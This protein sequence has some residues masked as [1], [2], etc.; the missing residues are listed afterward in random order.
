MWFFG[1]KASGGYFYV[2]RKICSYIFSYVEVRLLDSTY[3]VAN[4]VSRSLLQQT[5]HLWHHLAMFF[6]DEL[7]SWSWRRP[8]GMPL[9]PIGGG[10]LN[11]AD[12]K[13]KIT[14]NVEHVVNR[15]TGIAPQSISDEVYISSP[16]LYMGF[17]PRIIF[18]KCVCSTYHPL[19]W[20]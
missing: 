4:N 14:T 16:L 7:I 5:Q 15:V 11:N 6:R 20:C 17:S 8:L 3:R 10:S 1:Y 2:F 18:R 13:I 12:L 19:C 9:A